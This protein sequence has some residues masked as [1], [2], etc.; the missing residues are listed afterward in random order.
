[1]K[2]KAFTLVELLVVIS[3]MAMLMGILMPALSR[4][5]ALA[6]QV[7][8]GAHLS[9]IGKSLIVY[10]NEHNNKYVRAGG[11]NSKWGGE[12]TVWDAPPYGTGGGEDGAYGAATNN[13][14]SIGACL[15]YLI[16]YADAS[17]KLFICG[18]DTSAKELK[19]SSY[20]GNK[21]LNQNVME[22]WD[23]GPWTDTDG[24]TMNILKHYSYAYHYP[25]PQ[26]G[27]A[28][29]YPVNTMTESGFAIMADKSPYLAL[30]PDPAW[31]TYR[32]KDK[33]YRG[34]KETEK[35]GN[36]PNHKT[37]GQNVLFNDG[38]VSFENKPYCG[39]DN[40]NIYS[41]N[42]PNNPPQVGSIINVNITS[43][44]S[45][46][47]CFNPQ[48]VPANKKDSLLINEGYDQGNILEWPMPYEN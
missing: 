23:F 22:A 42:L 46:V 4:A 1:M 10:A 48:I 9:G 20:P 29:Y 32:W 30:T 8:C 7:V 16:K 43:S 34:N 5:R 38:S 35:W 33:D 44:P 47:R 37:E 21:V 17:P 39:F 45:R 25:F 12:A 14:A 19:L 31:G 2:R 40:D 41:M 27:Q 15:Y 11:S 18:G 28:G 6:G 13:K 3:I 36:S 24:T 26:T